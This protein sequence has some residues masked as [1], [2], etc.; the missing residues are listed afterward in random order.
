MKKNPAYKLPKKLLIR[1]KF[2]HRKTTDGQLSL[3]VPDTPGHL[4][5]PKIV[6]VIA[7]AGQKL[8]MIWDSTNEMVEFWTTN[9][10]WI[11]RNQQA[12]ETAF[13]EAIQEWKLARQYQ[14]E[15]HFNLSELQMLMENL[16]KVK[17]MVKS[18]GVPEDRATLE[19]DLSAEHLGAQV[20]PGVSG[21][22]AHPIQRGAVV[23]RG[24]AHPS[25]PQAC[26]ET[27]QNEAKQI[28]GEG[29]V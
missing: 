19:S 11:L 25:H 17:S 20:A 8:E 7:V 9:T 1:R 13:Q 2:H 6:L 27:Y 15:I 23:I 26:T 3:W 22:D 10:D 28:E 4:F 14:K 21:D 29:K 16:P 5:R 18:L 24:D 12:I